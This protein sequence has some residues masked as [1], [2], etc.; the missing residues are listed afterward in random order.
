[1]VITTLES[2]PNE[3]LT[4]LFEKYINGIDIIHAFIGQQ[5]FRFD[6]IIRGCQRISFD[7]IHCSKEQFD[8]CVVRLRSLHL[9]DKIEVL[10]LSDDRATGQVQRFLSYYFPIGFEFTRLRKLDISVN[11]ELTFQRIRALRGSLIETLTIRSTHIERDSLMLFDHENYFFGFEQ[12][13]RLV[14]YGEIIFNQWFSI[15]HERNQLQYLTYFGTPIDFEYLSIILYCCPQLRYFNVKL[16]ERQADDNLRTIPQPVPKFHRAMSQLETLIISFS[17][18]DL[19]IKF[20]MLAEHLRQM[21]VLRRLQIK[22]HSTEFLEADKWESL[23]RT[24]L[25][26]LTQFRLQALLFYGTQRRDEILASFETEYWRNMI[27]FYFILIEH[28]K[29]S[30]DGIYSQIIAE[31]VYSYPVKTWWIVPFRALVDSKPMSD[32][33]CFYLSGRANFLTKYYYFSNVKSLIVQDLDSDLFDWFQQCFNLSSIE[34]IDLS[35][36]REISNDVHRLLESLNNLTKLRITDQQLSLIR[37]HQIKCLDLCYS[38]VSFENTD[39]FAH[40]SQQF[41]NLEHLT[42]DIR[43]L[44][45]NPSL[46]RCLPK[47]RSVTYLSKD[48]SIYRNYLNEMVRWVLENGFRNRTLVRQSYPWKTIWI[49]QQALLDN[50]S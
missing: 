4:L 19:M 50:N 14:L 45:I 20:D 25:P 38:Q 31:D 28:K 37:N 40:I 10:Y 7:F 30:S 21:P 34:Y 2:L 1:M 33:R 22:T 29:L 11:D 44:Y 23:F 5:N 6:D 35:I 18:R 13:K 47:L 8:T 39:L 42:V 16:N 43:R 26:C 27:D 17:E 24:S 3:V 48:Q 49:D 36:L 32:I 15:H 46:R 41:P 12:L 9:L